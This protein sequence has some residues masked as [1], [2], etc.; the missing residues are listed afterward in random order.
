MAVISGQ[1]AAQSWLLTDAESGVE[2]GNWQVDSQQL[3]LSGERFS[4]E[5]KVLHGGK[6]EGSKVLILTSQ[7]GLTIALSPAVAWI[8]CMLTVTAF[9]WVGTPRFRR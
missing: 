6:Q 5:Q 7:N 8:C 3:K 2:K 1:A 4:I 9:A